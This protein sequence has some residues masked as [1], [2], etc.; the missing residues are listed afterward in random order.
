MGRAAPRQT[1]AI[2]AQQRRAQTPEGLLAS[3]EKSYL[4]TLH[5]NAQRLLRPL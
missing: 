3:N 5:Q 4:T 1:Q 2:H